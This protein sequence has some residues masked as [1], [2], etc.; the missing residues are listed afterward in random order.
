MTKKLEF[1]KEPC[2]GLSMSDESRDEL[3]F[4]EYDFGFDGVSNEV[5]IGPGAT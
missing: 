2:C 4:D 1:I 3:D 5:V